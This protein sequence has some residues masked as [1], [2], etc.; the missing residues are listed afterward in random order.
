MIEDA[1]LGREEVQELVR[2]LVRTTLEEIRNDIRA[3]VRT[4]LRHSLTHLGMNANDPIEAQ[5]DA[6][7]T[8]KLRMRVESTASKISA[9]IVGTLVVGAL[10][11]LMLGFMA[12]LRGK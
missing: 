4:E 10:S 6:L 9:T 11:L 2:D 7:F 5:A 3:E 8:R 1:K 12:F